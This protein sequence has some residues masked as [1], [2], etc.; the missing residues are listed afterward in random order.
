MAIK[1]LNEVT[2]VFKGGVRA[3]LDGSNQKLISLEDDLAKDLIVFA[4][5]FLSGFVVDT[6]FCEFER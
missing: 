5:F 1:G 2:T 6:C 3:I 4:E